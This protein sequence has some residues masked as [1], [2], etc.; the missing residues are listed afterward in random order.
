MNWPVY[1]YSEVLL[2]LAEALMEQG[3]NAEAIPYLNQVRRRAG[4]AEFQG[5]DLREAI[6][7]ERRVELAFENKRWFDLVRT[8]RAIEVIT[9]Y[10][11]RIKANPQAYYYPEGYGPRS[12][13]FSNISLYYALPA[14]EA[15]LSPHF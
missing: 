14:D 9:A 8:G 7:Q 1:R 4:L 3:K 10:G 11:N 2:F 5:G 13:A 15:A 12:H 6:Y